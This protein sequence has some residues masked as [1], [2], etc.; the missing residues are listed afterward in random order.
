VEGIGHTAVLS[1]LLTAAF[2]YADGIKRCKPL[3]IFHGDLV[4]DTCCRKEKKLYSKDICVAFNK[5]DWANS[6]NLRDWVK[7]QYDM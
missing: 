3:L 6:S 2:V 7:K 4:V 1:G 5:T